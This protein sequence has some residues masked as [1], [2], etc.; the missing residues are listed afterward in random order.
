MPVFVAIFAALVARSGAVLSGT[1]QGLH[2]G[3]FDGKVCL[4]TGGTAGIGEHAA[5]HLVQEGCAVVITGRRE[6]KGAKVIEALNNL[7]GKS[8]LSPSALFVKMDV[9]NADEVESGVSKIEATYGRLDAVFANAGGGAAST[10][11]PGTPLDEWNSV[12][13]TNVNGVFYTMRFSST[14]MKKT[15]PKK[16]RPGGSI[17]LCSSILGQSSFGGYA[18][19]ITSKHALEGL[20][21]AAAQEFG[22]TIRV[23]NV[24]PSFT[25][26]DA[27]DA[28]T[29]V[30]P[31]M[32]W[33]KRHSTG[34]RLTEQSEVSSVVT[35]LLSDD[36][37]YVSA[38]T[39]LVDGGAT[40]S[41]SPPAEQLRLGE[42]MAAFTAEASKAE[43]KTGEL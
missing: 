28:A 16:D 7:K 6:D 12:M 27:L 37:V 40:S 39:I 13:N 4:V 38:Q 3:R 29:G 15:G 2:P 24:G 21:K 1:F 9:G 43:Q 30:T 14:L 11:G 31:F 36:S 33:M 34:G 8:K 20:K 42:E 26:S 41:F 19:Y 23:N 17:V 32:D 25:S 5:H 22:L 18:A 35:W 10:V